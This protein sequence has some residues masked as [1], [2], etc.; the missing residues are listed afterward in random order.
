[1]CVRRKDET[2]WLIERV[3]LDLDGNSKS[4]MYFAGLEVF[5]T[6]FP[7]LS[8]DHS[9]AVRFARKEDAER[10]IECFGPALPHCEARNH[11]WVQT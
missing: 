4:P 7:I 1:M 8:L 2:G 5:P 11:M 10:M 3:E 9:K 6:R